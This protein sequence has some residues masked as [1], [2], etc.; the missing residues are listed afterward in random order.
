MTSLK[1]GTSSTA[2]H[3]SFNPGR[4][5]KGLSIDG[6][7]PAKTGPASNLAMLVKGTTCE[8]GLSLKPDDIS[9]G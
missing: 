8:Q 2:N 5:L 9:T 1:P 3:A 7:S 4:S 6:K